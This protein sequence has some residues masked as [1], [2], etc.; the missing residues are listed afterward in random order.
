MSKPGDRLKFAGQVRT[1]S[2]SDRVKPRAVIEIAGIVT[3]VRDFDALVGEE[4]T[5]LN[6]ALSAQQLPPVKV[7]TRAE[8][9]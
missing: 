4:L 1:G 8:W 9:G 2:G 7:I 5:G 3:G 6:A